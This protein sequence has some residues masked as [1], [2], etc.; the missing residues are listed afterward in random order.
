MY[1]C[2]YWDFAGLASGFCTGIVSQRPHVEQNNQSR[3]AIM[4][5]PNRHPKTVMPIAKP[6]SV[7]LLP[8]DRARV[9][10]MD[11]IIFTVSAIVGTDRVAN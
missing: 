5:T 2:P 10:V 4:A 8:N 6:E 1:G 7:F 9:E 11:A 3:A